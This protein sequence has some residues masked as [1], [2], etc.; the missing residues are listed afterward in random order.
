MLVLLT[1][2]ILLNWDDFEMIPLIMETS[3]SHRY[4]RLSCKSESIFFVPHTMT[5][6]QCERK[7]QEVYRYS[8]RP[9]TR[10]I[11]E[12]TLFFLNGPFLIHV[13]IISFKFHYSQAA[14]VWE[15]ATRFRDMSAWLGAA[16]EGPPLIN[17][18]ESFS[19]WISS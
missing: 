15:N 12:Y 1:Q 18:A 2:T 17:L 11:K 13:N 5:V 8:I 6:K 4:Q 10:P 7:N 16:Y 9:H 19:V 3:K 14:R